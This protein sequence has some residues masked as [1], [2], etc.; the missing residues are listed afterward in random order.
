MRSRSSL[1][2]GAATRPRADG[3]L[4]R[5]TGPRANVPWSCRAFPAGALSN[6]ATPRRHVEFMAMGLWTG[7]VPV[8]DLSAGPCRPFLDHLGVPPDELGDQSVDMEPLGKGP[9]VG[10]FVLL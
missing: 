3:G 7:S 2:A 8:V 5:A 6:T 4:T 10:P 1:R 9:A